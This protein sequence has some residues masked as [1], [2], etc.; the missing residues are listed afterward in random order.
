MSTRED[1]GAPVL[2]AQAIIGAV[3]ASSAANAQKKAAQQAIAV[4][5]QQYAQTRGDLAPY[6]EGGAADFA[7]YNDLLGTGSGGR[8]A[9][10][11]TLESLPGYQ[12]TLGQGLKST[13]NAAAA[14]GL[15]V[16]GAALKGAASYAT[17]LANGTYGTYANQLLA[18][19][20]LG[21]SASAATGQFGANAANQIG[22]DYNAIGNAQAAGA[23]G[24]GKAISAPLAQASNLLLAVGT[25]GMSTLAS[26]G[27]NGILNN[28]LGRGAQQGGFYAGSG[29]NG[30]DP[31]VLTSSNYAYG[32]NPFGG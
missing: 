25:D 12:F 22:Q 11:S 3:S 1:T 14:R 2:V 29:S 4:Q 20:Q 9:I 8:G 32:R 10:Q 7:K 6:R 28:S 17:G 15:G 24:I 31:N 26:G 27:L 30:Y 5:Q 23:I 13:Q 21:E 19:G 18:G 16:S